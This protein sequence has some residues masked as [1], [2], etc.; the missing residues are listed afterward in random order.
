MSSETCP[1]VEGTARQLLSGLKTDASILM[2]NW[3]TAPGKLPF[4]GQYW[5]D[6]D[7]TDFV[8]IVGDSLRTD[9]PPP[10]TEWVFPWVWK[11]EGGGLRFD[12]DTVRTKV[13]YHPSERLPA[14]FV[15]TVRYC[16]KEGKVKHIMERFVQLEPHWFLVWYSVIDR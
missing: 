1:D 6:K 9:P 4:S 12:V 8:F 7:D 5:V 10:V 13:E 2:A 14:S 3:P 15:T 11:V 16:G